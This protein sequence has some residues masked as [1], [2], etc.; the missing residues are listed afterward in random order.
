MSELTPRTAQNSAAG[1]H[2]VSLLRD[3]RGTRAHG[4]SRNR[5][6]LGQALP[7]SALRLTRART[8]DLQPGG[9]RRTAGLATGLVPGGGD[10]SATLPAS[11]TNVVALRRAL[12]QIAPSAAA[13]TSESRSSPTFD[14][15]PSP[16]SL[17]PASSPTFSTAGALKVALDG[18]MEELSRLDA[19]PT[20]PVSLASQPP[21]KFM[22]SR[23][24]VLQ[25]PPVELIGLTMTPC[26]TQVRPVSSSRGP[27]MDPWRQ[28][29]PRRPRRWNLAA[30]RRRHCIELGPCW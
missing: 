9:H 15:A 12:S 11:S 5:R 2:D 30:A 25:Q 27:A 22:V 17:S 26:R 13:V 20:S 14:S 10:G 1:S 24:G 16:R 4:R 28:P 3:R 6:R 23:I 21:S 8:S 19:A 18:L 29:S 7:A